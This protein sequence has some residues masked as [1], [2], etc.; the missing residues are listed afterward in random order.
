LTR[1]RALKAT[2]DP[3]NVFRDNFNITIPALQRSAS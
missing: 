2:Y 1:L 3:D